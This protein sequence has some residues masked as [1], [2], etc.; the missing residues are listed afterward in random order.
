MGL[1]LDRGV[2]PHLDAGQAFVI[3]A[4]EPQYMGCQLVIGVYAATLFEKIESANFFFGDEFGY[5]RVFGRFQRPFQ[6]DKGP[7]DL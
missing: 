5:S 3:G 6:P 1:P 2:H 7:F 4:D